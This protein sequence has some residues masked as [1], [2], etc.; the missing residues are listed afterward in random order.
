MRKDIVGWEGHYVIDGLRVLSLNYKRTGK[1]RELKQNIRGG[2]LYVEL[3]K[4]GKGKK[5]LV[6]RL[7][8]EACIP[9]PENK[10]QVNHKNGIKTDNRIENLEWVTQSENRQHAFEIGLQVAL[11]GEK[12]GMAKHPD[13]VIHKIFE[14][15]KQGYLQREIAKEVGYSQMQISRIL[16]GKQRK[17]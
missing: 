14:M 15:D 10:P 2:Y 13:L 8:A 1:E 4:N 7:I 11:K 9:N 5:Y 6:H 3:W 17:L 16:R 12:H